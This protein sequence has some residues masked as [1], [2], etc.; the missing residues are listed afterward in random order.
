MA[1]NI[2]TMTHKKFDPP[3][4]SMYIPL[5]VGREMTADLGY[6]GD[7]TGDHIS[8]LNRYY[9]ELT[10]MYWIWKNVTAEYVG[11]CHYRRYLIHEEGH[12]FKEQELELLLKEYDVITTKKLLLNFSYF[13]GYSKNHNVRDLVETGNVIKEDFPEYYECFEQIVHAKR[14]YFG[15]ILVTSKELFDEYA[16][17][18]FAIFFKVQKRI[19]IEHYDDY[20]KRVFGFISEILLLVWVTQK[21]LKVYEATVGMLGEK[22]E[23][24]EMKETLAV[25]FGNKQIKEAK[26]YFEA[27]LK[28]RPDVLMEASDITGELKLSMQIIATA[29][30]EMKSLGVSILDKG[31]DYFSLLQFIRQIND[32]VERYR[33]GEETALERYFLQKEQV[34]R[35][36][37][38]IAV[39]M[40]C[41]NEAEKDSTLSRILSD[42]ERETK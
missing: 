13:D 38:E 33:D 31:R 7:N 26:T 24:R 2:Y 5:H 27:M 34:S 6:T 1:I 36:A 23:T 10:G 3:E 28:K 22:V 11:M 30:L 8:H 15:N 4:D 29:D 37:I 41:Q 25:Y 19:D 21:K 40:F 12:I 14:T 35:V 32:A 20:H 18:L 17:W 39:M 16:G 9:S 42:L